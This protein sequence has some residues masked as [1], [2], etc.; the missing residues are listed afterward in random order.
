MNSVPVKEYDTILCVLIII[1]PC[2]GRINVWQI[3]ELK[4]VDKK[5]WPIDRFQP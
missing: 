1:Q 4:V 5:N 3:T 2:S